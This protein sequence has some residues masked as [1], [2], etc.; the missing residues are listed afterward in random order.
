MMFA[1]YRTAND[2]YLGVMTNGLENTADNTVATTATTSNCF[3]HLTRSPKISELLYSLLIL[4]DLG[5]CYIFVYND[6]EQ[7]YDERGQGRDKHDQPSYRIALLF[8]SKCTVYN[9]FMR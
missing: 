1:G 8:S 7:C 2:L 5:A 3:H 9:E 6:R 4:L